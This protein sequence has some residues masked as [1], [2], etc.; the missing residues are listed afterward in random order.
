[1]ASNDKRIDYVEFSVGDVARSRDFYGKA[2]G[3]SFKDYGPD[4]CEF[5]DGRLTGGFAL[6]KPDKVSGGPLVILFA[7]NLDETQRQVEAA[8]GRIV[9][10]AY[11]FP[12]GRRFHFADPDGYELAVWSEA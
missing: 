7:K 2:F 12:G 10:P 5:N 6:G 9:K 8:G 3:W 1:M 11:S 4:Y